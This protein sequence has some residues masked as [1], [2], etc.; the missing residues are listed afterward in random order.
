LKQGIKNK[1]NKKR[2][3]K[4]EKIKTKTFEG[5]HLKENI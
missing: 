1:K 2:K 5:K 3:D 4:N